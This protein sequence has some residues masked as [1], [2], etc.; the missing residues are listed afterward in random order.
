MSRPHAGFDTSELTTQQGTSH[1]YSRQTDRGYRYSTSNFRS[2][3]R[4]GATL[5]TAGRLGGRTG[6]LTF[7]A[8]AC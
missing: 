7:P 4:Q 5:G 3:C 8:M 6:A 2:I 1:H